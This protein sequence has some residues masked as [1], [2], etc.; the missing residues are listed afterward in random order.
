MNQ[1]SEVDELRQ[2]I[3]ARLDALDNERT[4]LDKQIT[5]VE[6]QADIAD[7]EKTI[8]LDAL[9]Q[10]YDFLTDT[11]IGLNRLLISLPRPVMSEGTTPQS[12]FEYLEWLNVGNNREVESRNVQ[13]LRL[14][15]ERAKER[16]SEWHVYND[17]KADQPLL[18]ADTVRD[19]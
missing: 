4:T 12:W 18:T 11:Q 1:Q 3:T 8:R 9:N 6:S 17:S 2:L 13:L 10:Q 7:D 19:E 14:S 16:L 5:L 15:G